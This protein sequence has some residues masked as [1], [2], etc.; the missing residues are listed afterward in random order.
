MSIAPPTEAGTF[1]AYP[2]PVDS[3]K[4]FTITEYHS[5]IKLGILAEDGSCELLKGLVVHKMG[6]NRR[7]SL[8]TRRLREM[9]QRLLADC[10]CY[11][12][13]QEPLVALDSEPEPD[14][15]AVRG[16]AEDYQSEQPAAKDV[17]LVIE[18]AEAT[19]GNDRLAKKLIYAEAS[20]PVYWIVNLLA[21]QV[22][23]Y[24][25]PSGPAAQ[26]DYA[27]REI[28]DE[29]AEVP[30][31]VDGREIGRLKVKDILP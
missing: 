8:V 1:T 17:P 26:P 2:V 16:K 15:Y 12:D 14:V 30:V 4:R 24:T 20:I 27:S 23:V 9:V 6:K 19:L 21:R 29:G 11:V 3:L 13:S 22:E 18:V 25:Q 31:V 28:H 5:L 7:H 10:N